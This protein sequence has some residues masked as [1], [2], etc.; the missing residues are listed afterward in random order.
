MPK[1]QRLQPAVILAL[2]IG[3]AGPHAS[4]AQG[5][6][7]RDAK[8]I[9]SYALTEAGLL[10]YTQA[11]KN[12]GALTK[13]IPSNCAEGDEA[14]SLNDFV[15]RFNAIPGVQRAVQSAGMTTREYVVFMF[16]LF[17]NGM[18]AWAL[19]QPGGKLAPGIS[20]ANVDFY[21]KHE[22][23]LKKVQ[24]PKESDDCDD[25]RRDDE[26]SGDDSES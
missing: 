10:K 4:S 16:S 8:E 22:T 18:A 11:A 5:F 24:G 20:K 13:K 25:D 6:Q 21:K 7:D 17:Q 3:L 23:A 26:R 19:D 9:S 12:L 1:K 15:V 2:L 14:K